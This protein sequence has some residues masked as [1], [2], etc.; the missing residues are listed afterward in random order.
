M[1]NI[2]YIRVSTADQSLALQQNAMRDAGV[3]KVFADHGV[4]G[5]LASRPQLDAALA[6]MREGDTLTVWKLDRL[7]RSTRNVLELLDQLKVRG[8][9]FKSITDGL[10]TRGPFGQAMLTVLAAFNQLEHDT[11]VER[12][13]AGLTAAREQGKVGGRPSVMNASKTKSARVLYETG[14]HTVAEIAKMLGV[15]VATVYRHLGEARRNPVE[16]V[17]GKVVV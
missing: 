3:D 9:E 16:N 12:T 5:T 6:Y 2:G 15:G 4:S 11:I 1:A 10:D 17:D 14:E 8:V 7:G 13:R